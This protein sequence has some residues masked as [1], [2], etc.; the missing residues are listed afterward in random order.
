MSGIASTGQGKLGKYDLR[1]VLGRGAMGT[2]YDGWDPAIDRRVA[3]KTVRLADA[4]DEETAEALARFKREA[5]AAGRL[6]HPNIVGVYDYGETDQIAYIVMEF[7]EGRSLKNLLDQ[8]KKLPAGEAV[9]IMTQVLAG[10][11]YSH[12]RGVIHRDVKP[13]NMMLTTEGQVKIADFGI[14]RI[15]SSNMTSVGTV[16][17]TP[18]YM[19]PEQFLGE[20]VDAR[21]DIYAAGVMLYHL[22]TGERPYEGTMASITTKKLSTDTPPLPSA[23]GVLP[24]FDSVV[25][26]AMA[27]VPADRYPS[28]GAFSAAITAAYAASS[29]QPELPDCADDATIVAPRAGQSKPLAPA[30]DAVQAPPPPAI[31]APP[32]AEP[33]KRGPPVALIGG[34]GVLLA[35]AAAAAFFLLRPAPPSP[36]PQP[37]DAQSAV[38]RRAEPP[39]ASAARTTTAAPPAAAAITPPADPAAV[40]AAVAAALQALPCSTLSLADARPDDDG[41][42]VTGLIGFGKPEQA[43]RAAVAHAAAG[44]ATYWTTDAVPDGDCLALE[45]VRL[46]STTQA[47]SPGA[48]LDLTIGG[49]S[50]KTVLEDRTPIVPR[51]VM[52]NFAAW[53]TVVYL[54]N[55]GS[56]TQLYP[57]I[58]QTARQQKPNAVLTLTTQGSSGVGPPF[59]R[60]LVITLAT[61]KKLSLGDRPPGEST[62]SYLDA[63]LQAVK[64]V[65]QQGA[66]T[67]AAVIVVDTRAR[68]DQPQ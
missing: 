33:A 43:A 3:I 37:G 22:L 14:A 40:R 25:A 58:R 1:G 4:D 27:R 51:I 49:V 57:E 16:M 36:S 52:P 67:A 17:G 55:D 10:L 38:F 61:A 29:Q 48:S 13:A 21:S 47:G 8:E 20:P 54:T 68:S 64:S 9:E 53:P 62:A 63:L 11:A 24:I 44:T 26:R 6:S 46:A 32:A 2:V 15:E 41:L 23:R 31:T 35:G 65:K 18:A 39:P 60:D 45:A 19:P 56:Q 50:G 66:A 28:A 12:A 34:G 7:V 59:G 42:T 5:Q 30:N